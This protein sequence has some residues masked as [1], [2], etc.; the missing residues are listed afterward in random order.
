MFAKF[1]CVEHFNMYKQAATLCES[2]ASTGWELSANMC[3]QRN[4]LQVVG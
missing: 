4:T 3:K 2:N 1:Y